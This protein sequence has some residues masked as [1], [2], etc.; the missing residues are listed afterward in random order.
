VNE[1]TALKLIKDFRRKY[2]GEGVD[3][4]VI[5]DGIEEALKVLKEKGVVVALATSKPET[6]AVHILKKSGL[7]DYFDVIQGANLDGSLVFKSDIVKLVL[8][9]PLVAGKKALMVGDT[10]Y[11]IAGAHQNGID[12]LWVNYGFGTKEEAL[13]EKTEYTAENMEEMIEFFKKF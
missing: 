2:H 9:H 12:T 5:Y 11:D 8:E 6:M 1:E 7:Y 3:E 13:L 4:F 10:K